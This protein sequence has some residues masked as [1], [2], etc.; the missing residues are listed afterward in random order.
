MQTPDIIS[1]RFIFQSKFRTIDFRTPDFFYIYRDLYHIMKKIPVLLSLLF[2]SMSLFAQKN[3]KGRYV[4]KM[5]GEFIRPYYDTLQLKKDGTYYRGRYSA[6]GR[7]HLADQG[8]YTFANDSTLL[9][10]SAP[11]P[12][13]I[14][15]V[16]K[17]LNHTEEKRS[18]SDSIT[19]EI[20][21][22]DTY[23]IPYL[24]ITIRMED[25]TK[26]SYRP[27][28]NGRLRIAEKNIKD[29]AVSLDADQIRGLSFSYKP[30]HAVSHHILEYRFE[31]NMGLL[32]EQPVVLRKKSLVL[33]HK[34]AEFSSE[35]VKK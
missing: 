12:L 20:V 7:G 35:F 3:I 22:P 28:V 8:T 33:K 15:F 17:D 5:T 2:L 19:F 26:K 13:R 29:F 6:R 14:D 10:T 23:A 30:E 4:Y 24:A 16:Y 9:L 18:D 34:N 11:N 25:G 1:K 31:R 32:Y 21:T 27:D